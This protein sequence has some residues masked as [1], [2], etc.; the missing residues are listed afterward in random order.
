MNIRQLLRQFAEVSG[1]QLFLLKEGRPVEPLHRLSDDF[2]L[3][4]AVMHSLPETL[5]EIWTS[6]APENFLMGGLQ[7]KAEEG[8][9]LVMPVFA[10][11]C[12]IAQARRILTRLGHDADRA[13]TFQR[14]MNRLSLYDTKKLRN[15]LQFLH[16]LCNDGTDTAVE[17]VD[18]RWAADLRVRRSILVQETSQQEGED[19]EAIITA[20][21]R[22]GKARALSRFFNDVLFA[23][24]NPYGEAIENVR[25]Q[26][27]YMVGA[28][29]YM[30]RVAMA[31]GVD[32]GMINLAVDRYSRRIEEISSSADFN[33]IFLEFSLYYTRLVA[34]LKKIS[35]HSLPANRLIQYV[36][37]HIYEPITLSAVADALGYSKNYLC[38]E[39]KKATGQTVSHFI[40]DNK[41][42][43]ACYLLD[44]HQLP[45]VE[46]SAA[47]SFSDPGYF[48]KVFKK[49]TGKTPGQYQR[50]NEPWMKE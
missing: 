39:F 4:Q 20:M 23:H 3:A 2:G 14:S 28:N 49:I 44:Q 18:F 41:I 17:H 27:R 15:L 47:L 9:L 46:I 48:N 35:T 8:R 26:R 1:I 31:E 24:N 30:S 40:A 16:G 12:T 37:S 50:S 25:Q 21:I 6:L 42:R 34:D 11:D 10:Y 45:A 32:P 22:H 43:E 7:W 38:A 19:V 5:P 29:M 33:H 13:G 36:Q